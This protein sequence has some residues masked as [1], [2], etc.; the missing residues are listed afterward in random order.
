MYLQLGS[1]FCKLHYIS[2]V[3]N[4]VLWILLLLPR[5][6]HLLLLQADPNFAGTLSQSIKT[7]PFQEMSF[8]D[9][10]SVEDTHQ[11]NE[12][13]QGTLP[14]NNGQAS[15]LGSPS[16]VATLWVAHWHAAETVIR[17]GL[18]DDPGFCIQMSVSTSVPVV[19]G[20]EEGTGGWWW[21]GCELRPLK[22]FFSVVIVFDSSQ[23]HEDNGDVVCY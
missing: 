5:L 12:L 17:A 3:E 22:T 19:V 11:S 10:A 4:R 21:E 8:A 13:G 7:G 6:P 14:G 1:Y 15:R 2:Q 16:S 23:Q 9:D 20:R 18:Y